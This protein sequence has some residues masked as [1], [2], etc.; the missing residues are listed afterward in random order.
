MKE[1]IVYDVH[2]TRSGSWLRFRQSRGWSEVL[3]LA[4]TRLPIRGEK[5]SIRIEWPEFGKRY[6]V[7][8]SFRG[9]VIEPEEVDEE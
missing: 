2:Q 7:E 8:V 1:T 9:G 5:D 4:I 6:F 3:R